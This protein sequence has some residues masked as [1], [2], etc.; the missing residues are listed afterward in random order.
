MFVRQVTFPISH[1]DS[2]EPIQRW[3]GLLEVAESAKL[4]N[5]Q[6]QNRLF[7]NCK[8]FFVWNKYT[9]TIL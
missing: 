9:F 1:R 2:F 4:H 6:N 5:F 7:L 8:S 3:S